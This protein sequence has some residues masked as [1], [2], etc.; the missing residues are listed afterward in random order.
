MSSDANHCSFVLVADFDIDRGAQLTYQ[1][2]Q[3]LGVDEG[4]LANLMLP[5]GAE[6]QSTDWTIFFLNQTP[7]NTIAPILALDTPDWNGHGHTGGEKDQGDDEEPDM[8]Y[9]LNLVRT[10]LDK[11]ARRGAVVKAMAICSR[12]PFIHIFKARLH[13]P[14]LL[15]ALDHYFNNPSQ[16]SLAR[17]FDSVNAM[18]LSGAP[19][20][21]RYEKIIMRTS[22][23]LDILIERFDEQGMYGD[24]GTATQQMVHHA[25]ASSGKS[26]HRATNSVESHSSFEEGILMRTRDDRSRGKESNGTESYKSSSQSKSPGSPSEASFSLDGSAVWVGD[27]SGLDQVGIG[28]PAS[29]SSSSVASGYRGRTST[30]ASSSSS[31]GLRKKEEQVPATTTAAAAASK[32][33]HFFWTSMEYGDTHLPAKIPLSTFPEEVG[34]ISVYGLVKLFS[35]STTTMTGPLHPHLHSNGTLTPYLVVLFNALIT[36]KRIIFLGHHMPAQEVS[37]HVLA[38][39]MLGSGCG[40]VLRG[41]TKRAFPYATLIN[42]EEWENVPGYIAGVTNPIFESAGNWDLL[43]DINASRIVISKDIHT[44]YPASFILILASW[45][46]AQGLS[47]RKDPWQVKKKWP[48]SSDNVFA[49]EVWAAVQSRYVEPHVRAKFTEYVARFVRTAS[50]YEEDVFGST[51]IG[52]P[53]STYTERSG[54]KSRLGSGVFYIDEATC[55]REMSLNASRIEAWRRTETYKLFQMDWKKIWSMGPIQG[56]DL[57]HQLSRLR[58]AKRMPDGEVELIMRTLAENLQTYD[59]VTELLSWMPPHL[60]GLLP[61]SFGLFHQQESVR[62]LT[63]DILNSLRTYSVGVQFLQALNHFQRYAYVRQAHTKEMHLREQNVNT[64]TI[65]A[66]SYMS[67]TPSNRSESSFGG[68]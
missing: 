56:F 1:F 49:E 21:T 52:Y 30:D 58:Y 51:T 3:P 34:D 37:A 8:L 20:L 7:F 66:S 67:R 60:N 10:K 64:L 13:A 26:S 32:D 45:S 29:L 23:R 57:V 33:S 12:H 16:D 17:L 19:V 27:E 24:P 41:F 54:E 36:G 53:S 38:A 18:D 42:R 46:F 5:D 43:C 9:V 62:D 59:Q 68:G 28:G 6:K 61:L 22:E 50:R 40:V 44:N 4:L 65:P 39:C 35:Q 25:P 11:T 47:K 15:M 31:H 2:P 48:D 63:V 55:A 14:I